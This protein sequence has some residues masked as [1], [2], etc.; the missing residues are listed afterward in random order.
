MILWEWVRGSTEAS[1]P[2]GERSFGG[3]A[4][5][6]CPCPFSTLRSTSLEE[7]HHSALPGL[8]AGTWPQHPEIRK[9]QLGGKVR[10]RPLLCTGPFDKLHELTFLIAA[11][12]RNGKYDPKGA[13]KKADRRRKLLL[14]NKGRRQ[15]LER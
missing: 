2:N 9:L 10:L 15:H 7:V 12:E 1:S 3:K 5:T 13:P 14:G 8:I 11:Y 6:E 4:P